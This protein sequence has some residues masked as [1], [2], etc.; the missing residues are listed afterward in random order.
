MK[1]TKELLK[2]FGIKCSVVYYDYGNKPEILVD[3]GKDFFL[4]YKPDPKLWESDNID[5]AVDQFMKEYRIEKLNKL[6]KNEL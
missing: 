6:N 2:Q 3:N 1:Y 5:I 4:V